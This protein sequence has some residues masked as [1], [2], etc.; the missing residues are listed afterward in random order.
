MIQHH[1]HL[2]TLVKASRGS[3]VQGEETQTQSPMKAIKEIAAILNLFHQKTPECLLHSPEIQLRVPQ[4]QISY[5][6]TYLSFTQSFGYYFHIFLF[7]EPNLQHMDV[8]RVGV[9]SELQLLAYSH[10][11]A[12]SE[13]RL[14]PT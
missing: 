6:L 11:N 3:W 12:R 1:F 8:P 5:L 2:I 13:P 7:L 9:E 14:Q 4:P 10:S